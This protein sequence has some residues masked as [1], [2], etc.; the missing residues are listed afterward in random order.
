MEMVIKKVLVGREVCRVLP[1]NECFKQ[2]LG[3]LLISC[4]FYLNSVRT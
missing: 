1:D 2:I 3:A 4:H